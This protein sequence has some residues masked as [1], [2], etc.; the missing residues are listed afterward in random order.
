VKRLER[1]T[2]A[3]SLLVAVTVMSAKAQG[4]P[5][6]CPGPAHQF[7][8]T[9]APG[10]LDK[11]CVR[12]SKGSAHQIVWKARHGKLASL[13]FETSNEPHNLP[14]F[15]SCPQMPCKIPCDTTGRCKSGPI[16]SALQPPDNG[17]PTKRGYRYG[18]RPLFATRAGAVDPSVMI[19]P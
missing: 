7:I 11:D 10:H 8:T 14:P 19:D 12:I 15:A 16:N 17:D 18:Y 6:H 4:P 2:Y 13:L 3:C 9:D 5:A 1:A